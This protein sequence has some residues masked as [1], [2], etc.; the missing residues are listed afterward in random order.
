[1]RQLG[2]AWREQPPWAI[3]PNKEISFAGASGEAF[4]GPREAQHPVQTIESDVDLG[5]E[6]G[7]SA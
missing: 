3:S 2:V 5:D 7:A 4:A 6:I 1:L